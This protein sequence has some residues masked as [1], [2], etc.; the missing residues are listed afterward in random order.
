MVPVDVI[1]ASFWMRFVMKMSELNKD[2][3]VN[4]N[5]RNVSLPRSAAQE[6]FKIPIAAIQLLDRS[7]SKVYVETAASGCP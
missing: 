3:A 7:G 2:D 6:K 4:K 5:N 1:R